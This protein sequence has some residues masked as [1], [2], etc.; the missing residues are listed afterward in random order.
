M[1]FWLRQGILTLGGKRYSLDEMR[2]S[3][4]VT[5]EDRPKLCVAE[6]EIYNLAP[7]TRAMLKKGLAVILSAGYK[8]DV[9][10]IFVGE[11][12]EFNTKIEELDNITKIKAADSMEAWL[13]GEVN[14]TYKAGMNAK[15]II[16]DL[17]N[18]F[19]VEVS[20]IELAQ[21]KRYP[22]ARTC[23]GKLKDVLTELVCSDCKSRL[24]I[25]TGQ[26]FINDPAQGVNEG[27]LLTPETGLLK[28]SSKKE[29]Q[30]ANT[31][32]KPT[33]KTRAKQKEPDGGLTKECLLNHNLGCADI[34]TIQDS[35]TNGSYLIIKGTHE[36][37]RDAAWK[38]VMSLKPR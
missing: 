32:K 5:F 16:D 4:R 3:F 34:V 28:S 12:R 30:D 19:G 25:R 13:S 35:E 17:L 20:R 10:T 31:E 29:D 27:F 37:T 1:R 11:I 38:T 33:K 22:R 7:D 18:I 9:G 8:G 6:I 36:G 2:F 21:N 15:D 23:K 24:I 14:K 26:I